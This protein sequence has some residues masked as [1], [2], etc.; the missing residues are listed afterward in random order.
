MP[1]AFV[2]QP[3]RGMPGFAGRRDCQTPCLLQRSPLHS[4]L[5]AIKSIR[6]FS[7]TEPMVR[8]YQISSPLP[9]TSAWGLIVLWSVGRNSTMDGVTA[10][11]LVCNIFQLVETGIKIGKQCKQ[12][13]DR[14]SLIEL[15]QIEQWARE[16]ADANEELKIV[17]PPPGS[18]LTASH[19]R[20]QKL[21]QDSLATTQKL[22][23]ILNEIKFDRSTRT[24]GSLAQICQKY[25]KRGKLDELRTQLQ[26][27]E[28]Q[29]DHTM[30]TDL[31]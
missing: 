18:T 20:I 26:Q 14:G 29:I 13:H 9:N 5:R 23:E 10:L 12:V 3:T 1:L 11:G 16:I 2:D 25:F 8:L 28:R 7:F 31:Q 21:A 24:R 27:M 30:V 4:F 22:K 17:L 15:D 6:Q 19:K